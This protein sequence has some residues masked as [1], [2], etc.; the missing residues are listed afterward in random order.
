MWLKKKIYANVI[1]ETYHDCIC[2]LLFFSNTLDI[3]L[4]KKGGDFDIFDGRLLVHP[5]NYHPKKDFITVK[6]ITASD[7]CKKIPE[8]KRW[9]IYQV[10]G[11]NWLQFGIRLGQGRALHKWRSYLVC[12]SRVYLWIYHHHLVTTIVFLWFN[13]RFKHGLPTVVI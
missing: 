6:R 11:L 12:L 1:W 13:D 7:R 4:Q 8:L 5:G 9:V 3:W 10:L 2:S